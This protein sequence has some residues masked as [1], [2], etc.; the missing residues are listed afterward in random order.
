[1]TGLI[2]NQDIAARRA[3]VRRT[4]ASTLGR[5]RLAGRIMQ[6]IGLSAVVVVLAPLALLIGYVI[7]RGAPA[8]S[9]SFFTHLPTPPGIPGGGISNALVGTLIIDGLALVM[10]IPI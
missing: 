6:G 4:A 2:L 3:L 8:L 9:W 1:M 5:R 10:A 7:Y